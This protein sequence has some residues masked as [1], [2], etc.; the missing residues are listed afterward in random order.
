MLHRDILTQGVASALTAHTAS[1]RRNAA[2]AVEQQRVVL[3]ETMSPARKRCPAVTDQLS[4]HATTVLMQQMKHKVYSEV[5]NDVECAD[6]GDAEDVVID[7]SK[8]KL[9]S[10]FKRTVTEHKA[11]REPSTVTELCAHARSYW[12][13]AGGQARYDDVTVTC[14]EDDGVADYYVRLV[15]LVS[16]QHSAHTH[17]LQL[18]LVQWYADAQRAPRPRRV[19][20]ISDSYLKLDAQCDLMPTSTLNTRALLIQDMQHIGNVPH[21]KRYFVHRLTKLCV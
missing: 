13:H 14:E 4:E 11:D 5:L 1:T 12:G 9:H 15:A 21:D 6:V 20:R 19:V 18:A 10:S 17:T 7:A 16:Y 2:H 8:L 3:T